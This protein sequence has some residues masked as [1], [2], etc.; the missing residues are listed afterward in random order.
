MFYLSTPDRE[1]FQQTLVF[2]QLPFQGLEGDRSSI[3]LIG[4]LEERDRQ[5]LNLLVAELHPIFFHAS[6]HHVFQ[7]AKLYQ[8][9]TFLSFRNRSRITED[10]C[11]K[12][13]IA[14]I[15]KTVC[16]L[17]TVDVIN[18]EEESNL[19]VRRF[20]GKF[21]HGVEKFLKG[22]RAGIISVEYLED[23]FGEE[24]LKVV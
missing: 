8:S 5:V 14:K 6:S 22:Y 16:F 3:A 19:I 2:L 12:P 21:V 13:T 15:C 23:P 18:F 9:V 7:L 17:N 11:S 10:V 1:I 24:R 20:P 4:I